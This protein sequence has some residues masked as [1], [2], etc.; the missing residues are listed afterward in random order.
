[1]PEPKT[2][3]Q[4]NEAVAKALGLTRRLL[5]PLRYIEYRNGET[6]FSPATDMASALWAFDRWCDKNKM[7]AT[8]DRFD[9]RKR[10]LLDDLPRWSCTLEAQGGNGSGETVQEAI[11]EAIVGAAE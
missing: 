6:E 7:S 9:R 1:M 4:W 2:N 10:D 11:R 5:C 3:Q 8:I